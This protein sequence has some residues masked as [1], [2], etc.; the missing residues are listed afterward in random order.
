MSGLDLI[1]TIKKLYFFSK[2]SENLI[3]NFA[4]LENLNIFLK[5]KK[6][7]FLKNLKNGEQINPKL[8]K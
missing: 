6:N 1:K 3:N 7:I 8:N 5:F 4:K 2:N